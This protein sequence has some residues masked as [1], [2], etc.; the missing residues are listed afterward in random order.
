MRTL[1]TS[2]VALLV[3]S[4]HAAFGALIINGDMSID[5]NRNS[6]RFYRVAE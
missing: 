4:T 6:E 5:T 2:A 1:L 3:V